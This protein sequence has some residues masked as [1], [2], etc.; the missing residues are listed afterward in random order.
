MDIFPI[1]LIILVVIII[2][3]IVVVIIIIATNG[4]STPTTTNQCTTQSDC[5]TGFV[6]TYNNSA[7]TTTCK[8][9][10]G[11][12][13]ET[14]SDCIPELVCKAGTNSDVKICSEREIVTREVNHT[15]PLRRPSLRRN[16][17]ISEEIPSLPEIPRRHVS[18]AKETSIAPV[19]EPPIVLPNTV[20]SASPKVNL[21]HTPVSS[22]N[23]NMNVEDEINT[24]IARSEASGLLARMQNPNSITPITPVTGDSVVLSQNSSDVQVSDVSHHSNDEKRL[25]TQRTP[26]NFSERVID[27]HENSINSRFPSSSQIEF[28][29][30]SNFSPNEIDFMNA[31]RLRRYGQ[32]SLKTSARSLTDNF[33]SPVQSSVFQPVQSPGFHHV[34]SPGFQPVQSPGFHHV[35]S[36]VFQPVQSPGFHHV[37]SPGFQLKSPDQPIIRQRRVMAELA[38]TDDE[39][40]SDGRYTDAP[41]D[42]RSG[43]STDNQLDP[44]SSVSTPCQEKDGVY[45]CRTEKIA[46]P[47][48]KIT[49]NI[50]LHSS[51]VIDVCSYSTAV[52][53]LLEDGHIICENKT[54]TVK[55][56]RTNNNVKL[57]RVVSFGGYLY[58]V[59]IDEILY[60]LPNSHFVTNN[61]NWL[62]VD[63]A[64]PMIKYI[65]TTHDSSHLWI[66]TDSVGYLY[67]SPGQ[68]KL[69]EKC[70]GKKRVYGRDHCHYMDID[71]SEYTAIIYPEEKI[72]RDVYDAALSFYD[73]VI[74]IHPSES[75][76]YRGITI[77]NWQPYYI[78]V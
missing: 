60:T 29:D 16:L 4:T 54:S 70:E 37:Q 68:I 61:W 18:W 17:S 27:S 64:P 24:P 67:E 15:I 14:N 13:C 30:H 78:R 63:W 33:R 26:V 7:N 66:Q 47:L 49:E 38:S 28:G 69:K 23:I 10:L 12:Q 65:C 32:M 45:Y 6:C 44:I 46:D 75:E 5:A 71:L 36:S 39:I 72:V 41:F 31:S 62:P 50:G 34:Q 11:I 9:G 77:V 42:V 48:D 57:C 73:E 19:A 25:P 1:I 22:N 8:A 35:Q 43:D 3:S 58:G 2:I 40:N 21:V 59:G 74:A 53:F 55:R 56:Y 20:I 76:E 52:I 51:S